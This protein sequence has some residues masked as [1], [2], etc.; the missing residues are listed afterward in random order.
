MTNMKPDLEEAAAVGRWSV[1]Q[2]KARFSEVVARARSGKPQRV[3]RYGKEDVVIVD[4]ATFDASQGGRHEH[5][6]NGSLL[7]F[8]E[9]LRGSGLTLERQRSGGR[10]SIDFEHPNFDP[11]EDWPDRPPLLPR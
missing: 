5:W 7:D 1:A 6:L 8:F 2:A 4:A 10:R 11:P 3:S 9:P